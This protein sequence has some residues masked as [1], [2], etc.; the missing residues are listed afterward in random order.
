MFTKFLAKIFIKNHNDFNNE[1]V[2]ENYGY[3]GGAVGIVMNLILFSTKLILGIITS[4]IAITADAFNNLSDAASSI[5]TILGFKLSSKP[6]DKEH[7]FGHG[8]IEYLS[9]LI[10][11]FMV[12]FVG[13][14]FI[15]SSF[16]KIIN[17]SAVTFEIVPFILII[18]SIFIKLW[19]SYF[20]KYVGN[21][22]NSSALKA[23][24]LD[25]LV[26]VIISSFIAISL[27]ISKFTTIYIDGYLG[28]LISIF[29]IFSGYKMTKD[30]LSP[31]LGE[32]P[33][34]ELVKSIIDGV[35]SYEYISGAHDLIIHNYGPS[36]AMAT[37]HAEVPQD[38]SVVKLHEIID[39]AEKEL[40]EKLKIFLVIHMD[41]VNTNDE[42]VSYV[43]KEILRICCKLP[44]ISSIHDFRI[45]G[46]GEVKNILFDAVIHY[47]EKIT[48]LTEENLKN[49]I[50]SE[51]KQLHPNY[52]CIITL[53]R[54]FVSI[55]EH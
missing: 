33:S 39:R 11:S 22:I 52:N 30:T 42:E 15:K 19:L 36:R 18:V 48:P 40:S 44:Q 3:F 6:A 5:I 23:S 46:N 28:V 12:M 13:L 47:H 43:K 29:I 21:T 7:P 49:H 50:N 26:D 27:I 16:D 37:I 34:E 1:K 2:R 38:I 31:L 17:P 20:N 54:D 8:R 10:V 55:H 53:D 14:Q 45:V 24:S 35:T 4:S 25:A 32:A 9:G 51:L 41:P